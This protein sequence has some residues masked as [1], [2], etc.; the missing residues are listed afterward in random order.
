MKS[1]SKF[2]VFVLTTCLLVS[3]FAVNLINAQPVDTVQAKLV[4]K[5]FF[6]DRLSRSSISNIK[7][8]SSQNLDF[9]LARAVIENVNKQNDL[10]KGSQTLPLYY[11]FNVR[12][13]VN[14]KYQNGFIIVSA[15]QR[16]PAILGY[17][18]TGE[19]PDNDQPSALKDWMNHYKEQII[20][21]IQNNL[22]PGPEI[23]DE[24][25][26]YSSTVELKGTK[27]LSEVGP[28][29]TTKWSQY[30]FYNNLCPEDP[31]CGT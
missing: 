30:G 12:D 3:V 9:F 16:V 17:S 23:S 25:E 7:G 13:K 1:S 27:Q 15:D 18:F 11:I 28:L 26:K 2:F 14:T 8:I 29:I 5:N 20:Y 10:N 22:K 31:R 4:A 21:I 24:W 19:F 6:A